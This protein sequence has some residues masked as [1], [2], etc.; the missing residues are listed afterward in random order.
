M[1]RADGTVSK[2]ERFRR[3]CKGG[4]IKKEKQGRTTKTWGGYGLWRT[5][6][7]LKTSDLV[8]KRSFLHQVI[9]QA[10][11]NDRG[12]SGKTLTHSDIT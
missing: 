3:D 11:G 5:R 10:A 1:F 8:R 6:Y 9:E 12:V 7:P 2:V 4:R